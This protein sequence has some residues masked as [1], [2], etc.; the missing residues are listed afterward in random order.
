MVKS[1]KTIEELLREALVLREDQPYEI[2]DNWIWT[3]LKAI[4]AY[5]Q[6]GRSPKYVEQS[7]VRV[8]SQKCVQ[9]SGFDISLARYIDENSLKNYKAER[10]L[11][12]N[13]ILW[14]ST[15]T[16]TIGRLAILED[17]LE[18]IT[19]ADSH[20]TVVRPNN[21]VVISKLLFKWLSSPY[22]QNKLNNL[23]SGSTNQVELNLITVKNQLVPLPPYKE[24]K[25]IVEKV[26]RILNKIEVAKQL[27]EESK[28]MFELRRASIFDK[29]FRGE[30]TCKWKKDND[31]GE[32][33]DVLLKKIQECN[34]DNYLEKVKLAKVN[35]QS[36]PKKLDRSVIND[37]HPN[38]NIPSTWEWVQLGDLI[39]DLTDYHANG[40]YKILKE[41]VELLD[42]PN[43]ACMIRATNFEQNNFSSVMKY[44]T[45]SAYD[46]LA[47]SKLYGGEILISKIG[48]TGSVYLMPNLNKPCS[49]AMNLFALRISKYV[50]N[51][52]VY[53]YLKSPMGSANIDKY[54]RGVTTTSIDKKSVRSVWVPL[55]PINEQLEIKRLLKKCLSNEKDEQEMLKVAMNNLDSIKQSILS[56][57]FRGE[58]GTNDPS[59]ENAIELLKEI[60]QKQVK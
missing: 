2:P 28:E 51:E 43:Y 37:P 32:K 58:L 49:L 35:G 26:E 54:V 36:K 16:G 3:D 42:A 25:R 39:D 15:G 41:H 44:I 4:A 59:E 45:K 14:N 12:K 18:G 55:P 27:I 56:K 50:D 19:V 1:R 5:I 20:V 48:N 40:S 24:Q 34:D 13:D 11:R 17:E 46:F 60:L 23:W 38:I 52:F 21:N 53:Y 29:A 8:V 31:C 9:W 10:Y 7:G 30:L 22:V 57:A 6:R 47:K 33:P